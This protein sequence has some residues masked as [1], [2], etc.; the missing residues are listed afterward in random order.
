MHLPRGSTRASHS[1]TNTCDSGADLL[2]ITQ[3]ICT[4]ITKLLQFFVEEL[5]HALHTW[6]V[7]LFGEHR[8]ILLAL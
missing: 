8:V 3:Q 4:R 1:R 2:R 6:L 7:A 5:N